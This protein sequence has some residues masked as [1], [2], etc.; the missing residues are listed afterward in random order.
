MRNP[1]KGSG[2]AKR[3]NGF[4]AN[5]VFDF[6]KNPPTLF[7]MNHLDDFTASLACEELTD[8]APSRADLAASL[9]DEIP[10]S[11]FSPIG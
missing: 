3:E 5:F 10:A 6:P 9:G 7:L 8:F 4:N 1:T 2:I 11:S